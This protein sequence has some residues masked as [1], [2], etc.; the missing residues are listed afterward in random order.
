MIS[1]RGKKKKQT[2]KFQGSD[3]VRFRNNRRFEEKNDVRDGYIYTKNN[4]DALKTKLRCRDWKD[5]CKIAAYIE[6][7]EENVNDKSFFR[8]LGTTGQGLGTTDQA[9]IFS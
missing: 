9:F 8:G 5:G 1:D 6:N 7:G 2:P 4:S 3:I